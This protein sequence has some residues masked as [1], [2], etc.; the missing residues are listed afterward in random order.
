MIVRSLLQSCSVQGS[1]GASIPFDYSQPGNHCDSF[2]E[3]WAICITSSSF[4]N[5]TWLSIVSFAKVKIANA[6]LIYSFVKCAIRRSQMR[7][8]G[9]RNWAYITGRSLWALTVVEFT[10]SGLFFL[11]FYSIIVADSCAKSTVIKINHQSF[12]SCCFFVLVSFPL[13]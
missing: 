3:C 13:N 4:F 10:S 2:E 12:T 8:R 11:L 9:N 5:L 1:S 7:F 6:P